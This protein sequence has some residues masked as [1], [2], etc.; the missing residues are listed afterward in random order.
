MPETRRICGFLA[1]RADRLRLDR[2]TDHRDPR[3]KRWNLPTLLWAT[4][5]GVMTGQK[6]FADVERLTD[7]LSVPARR[8]FGIKGRVPDTTL[9][10]ALST[11]NPTEL[12][13][14]LHST[15]RSAMRSLFQGQC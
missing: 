6:S 4:L 2:V 9:R 8:R 3:G 7:D 1:A 15:I 12:R 10:D 11:I 14:V 5:L 13:P